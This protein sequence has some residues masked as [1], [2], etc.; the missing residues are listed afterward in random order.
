MFQ[1]LCLK[2]KTILKN[3]P[4]PKLLGDLHLLLFFL[5]LKYSSWNSPTSLSNLYLWISRTNAWLRL[6]DT[7][8]KKY[9]KLGAYKQQAFVSYSS[10]GWKSEIRLPVNS[11]EETLAGCMPTVSS[12]SSEQRGKVNSLVTF[13]LFSFWLH[14][15]ACATSLQGSDHTPYSGSTES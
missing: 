8:I 12:H 15:V 13:L 6:G 11:D 2:K 10:G 5:I 1:H 9:C 3:F 7:I 4:E 14:H